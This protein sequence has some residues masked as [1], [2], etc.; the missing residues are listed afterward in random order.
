MID[1]WF[2]SVV[3][4]FIIMSTQSQE[5]KHVWRWKTKIMLD[6][7]LPPAF[8]N[9]L[10]QVWNRFPIVDHGVRL[11]TKIRFQKISIWNLNVAWQY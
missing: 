6:L 9:Y 1:L 7:G 4:N 11:R 3:Q 8:Y 2:L 5:M 10:L